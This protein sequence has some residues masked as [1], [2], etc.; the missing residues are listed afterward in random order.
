MDYPE[1][2]VRSYSKKFPARFCKASGSMLTD[3]SGKTYLDF[4]SACGSL[5]YGHNHPVLKKALIEH[6]ETNGLAISLDLQTDT[7]SQF[8][9]A[10]QNHILLPR[11]YTYVAQFT[12]PT[13]AN[14]VEAAIKL[15]RKYTGKSH[16]IAFTNA[17]HGCT[18][19]A[20]G[21]T[22]N[23]Y[24]RGAS[25]PLLNHVTRMPYDGYTDQQIDT[26][27]LLEHMLEDPSSGCPKPAAIIFETIQGE[28]GLN[29]ASKAWAKKIA[30][31]AKRHDALLI[32]D[33]IQAGCGRS[34]H[35]FSFEELDIVPDMVT[36][37][38]SLSGFGLPMSLSLIKPEFDI[39]E[40]GEHN[41]TFRGNSHAFVTAT[42]AL[43]NFWS[44]PA[45]SD[46]LKSRIADLKQNLGFIAQKY[47]FRTKGRG[48][49]Q[50]ID[51]RDGE[52]CQSIAGMCYRNGLIIETCGSFDE[53]LKLLPAL[54]MDENAL[55]RGLDIIDRSIR[56][57]LSDY[58]LHSE[59]GQQ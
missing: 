22:A 50:G 28:G 25:E 56:K 6:I 7:R 57:V 39:W 36:L 24:H 46:G 51:F 41:G 13:G 37:A 43:N 35:F 26:A 33:D 11:D 52:L 2:N 40:P 49:M 48:F 17:F 10:L 8:L 38:K 16:I 44:S 18:L 4:L 15:A 19:G 21:L 59:P 55:S 31:L 32:V 45:F 3:T 42:A 9:Q 54:N 23:A 34:G 14:A 29:V 5:N 30:T 1:S 27:D 20:L 53:V 12:G 47:G 58:K